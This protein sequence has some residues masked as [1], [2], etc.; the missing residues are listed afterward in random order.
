MTSGHGQP[1]INL[2][3]DLIGLGPISPD[4]LDLYLQW[5]NDFEA[6]Q[7][8]SPPLIPRTRKSCEEWLERVSK[9]EPGTIQFG[10]FELSSLRPIGWTQL[11]NI[12]RFQ[13]TAE[14][15]IFIGD[16]SA[17]GKG[18]GTETTRL[19]LEYGFSLLHLHNIM[20]QVDSDNEAA[21]RAY[22]RAGFREFGRQRE[23]RWR[24]SG[25]CDAIYM[26]CLAGEFCERSSE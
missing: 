5:F 16:K 12:D 19:M 14:Y 8:Y 1:A 7:A 13:Q 3:G 25:R 20:L 2:R 17:W 18:Y 23:V 22:R 6:R 24:E 11:D 26:E 21:I 15:G 10:I 9:G 4:F